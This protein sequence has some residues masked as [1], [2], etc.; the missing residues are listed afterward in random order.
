MDENVMMLLKEMEV[1]IREI[2]KKVTQIYRVILGV[3]PTQEVNKSEEEV[4]VVES[5][6]YD[7]EMEMP[8]DEVVKKMGGSSTI[9]K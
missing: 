9:G 7:W 3:P 6:K 8:F 2:E 1:A 5:R 4:P